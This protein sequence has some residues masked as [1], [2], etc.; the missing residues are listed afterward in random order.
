LAGCDVVSNEFAVHGRWVRRN[1]PD[2][3]KWGSELDG[4]V[5]P[6]QLRARW[7]VSDYLAVLGGHGLWRGLHD[8]Q[9][10]LELDVA[11]HGHLGV[12]A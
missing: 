4:A 6:D 10:R 5:A 12:S 2:H 7:H 1:G 9:F 11:E 3:N 8:D